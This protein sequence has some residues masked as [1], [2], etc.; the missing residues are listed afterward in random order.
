M[1]TFYGQGLELKYV[2]YDIQIINSFAVCIN[3]LY[4]MG[5]KT[6]TFIEPHHVNPDVSWYVWQTL[7]CL[8]CLFNK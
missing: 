3:H 4:V 2:K 8:L 6:Q 5:S 1:A 7:H